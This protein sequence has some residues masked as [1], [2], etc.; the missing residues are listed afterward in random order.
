MHLPRITCPGAV[1][2]CF[3]LAYGPGVEQDA[4]A[5]EHVAG[6]SGGVFAVDDVAVLVADVAAGQ[7]L[8]LRCRE[9]GPARAGEGD[10][11]EA[12]EDG[13]GRHI[14]G[15]GDMEAGEPGRVLEA[16][17]DGVVIA[18]DRADLQRRGV[19][20][21]QVPV[22]GQDITV[23]GLPF[24]DPQ[25]DMCTGAFEQEVVIAGRQLG[26]LDEA[27]ADAHGIEAVGQEGIAAFFEE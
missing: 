11:A 25:G 13:E 26:D 17:G 12:L 22:A 2:Q 19:D 6:V 10:T 5:L 16:H 1:K 27:G 8:R 3:G 14:A 20:L 4:G 23:F 7:V 18:G 15:G 21:L 9:G 24:I